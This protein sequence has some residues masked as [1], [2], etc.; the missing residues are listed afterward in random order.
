LAFSY[1]PLSKS[2]GAPGTAASAATANVGGARPPL[3]ASD[4][5]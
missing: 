3:S 2:S 4:L 1:S 5:F